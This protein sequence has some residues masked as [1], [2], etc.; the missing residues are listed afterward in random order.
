M[1][2]LL[3]EIDFKVQR[4][5]PYISRCYPIT[6]TQISLIRR[7][8]RHLKVNVVKCPDTDANFASIE[9]ILTLVKGS[10]N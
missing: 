9:S 3:D 6:D 8:L 4:G 2:R 5:P 7:E 1:S 10:E